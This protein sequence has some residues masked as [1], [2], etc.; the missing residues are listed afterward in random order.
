[1]IICVCHRVSHHDIARAVREGCASFE[2]L[3]FEL[4]VA[5][6]CGA[7]HSCA[8]ETFEAQGCA[9]AQAA[10]GHHANHGAQVAT[11]DR[12]TAS[13]RR[14]IPVQALAAHAALA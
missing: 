1:M 8:R 6:G 4:Q 11:T 2:E 3:Q 13:V 5:T 12:A 9:G 10:H 7:C 14:L